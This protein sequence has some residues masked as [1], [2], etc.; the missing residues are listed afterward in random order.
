MH[1]LLEALGVGYFLK[2]LLTPA[3]AGWR[4]APARWLAGWSAGRERRLHVSGAL[5]EARRGNHFARRALQKSTSGIHALGQMMG[6]WL[7]GLVV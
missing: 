3:G 7:R 4:L 1:L 6:I 2:R 5:A